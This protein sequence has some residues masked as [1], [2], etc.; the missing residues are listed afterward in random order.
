M[1]QVSVFLPCF[2]A[3]AF[4]P[5]ALDSLA[6]QTFRDFDITVIDDGSDDPATLNLLAGLPDHI[7]VVRQS[8]QGLPA[9]RNAGFRHAT[10]RYVLPLDCDDQ[11]APEFLATAMESLVGQGNGAV[12]FAHLRM[13]GDQTGDLI[14]HFNGF[15]QLYFNQLPYCML[16]PRN[17]WHRTGGY[18]ETM[19]EGYEDWEFN[20]RLAAAGTEFRELAAPLFHYHVAAS[21]MLASKSRRQHAYLW[22]TIR[23][24]H[25]DLYTPAALWRSWRTWRRRPST[26]P[27]GLYFIWEAAYRLLPA[28]AINRLFGAL[29]GLSHSRQTA[30]QA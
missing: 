22:R 25:S 4:L 15:E 18:D 14:K 23:A 26:R 28:S 12:A 2:N 9:A 13:I 6:K 21:G 8:N 7:N 1:P 3:H 11:I 10:G 5:R 30:R 29:M 27:L 17:L 20:I 24:K 16:I 19:R